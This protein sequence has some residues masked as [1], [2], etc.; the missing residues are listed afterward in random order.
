VGKTGYALLN[1]FHK[2]VLHGLFFPFK[3]P[4][5]LVGD[6]SFTS[7]VRACPAGLRTFLL[8]SIPHTIGTHKHRGKE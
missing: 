2:F 7:T 1:C 3:A 6:Y 4:S 5:F 8:V